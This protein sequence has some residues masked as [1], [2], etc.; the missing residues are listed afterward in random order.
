MAYLVFGPLP[1]SVTTPA[2]NKLVHEVLEAQENAWVKGLS[3]T[4]EKNSLMLRH[5]HSAVIPPAW[6]HM[7]ET[8]A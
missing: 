8:G 7:P 5:R 1:A 2:M 3:R 6:H 4:I